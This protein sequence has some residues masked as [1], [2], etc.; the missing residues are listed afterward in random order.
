MRLDLGWFLMRAGEAKPVQGLGEV[1]LGWVGLERDPVIGT[2]KK[3]DLAGR[4]SCPGAP[5]HYSRRG[6]N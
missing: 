6:G 3:T 5:G 2:G 1:T 4:T